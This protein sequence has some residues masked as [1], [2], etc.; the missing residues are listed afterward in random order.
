ME[1]WKEEGCL[2]QSASE[3]E[4]AINEETAKAEAIRSTNPRAL[5]QYERY[6]AEV[7]FWMMKGVK[8]RNL[9]DFYF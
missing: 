1:Q 3:I 5:E 9:I 8:Q 6:M 4:Q 7:S 2:D